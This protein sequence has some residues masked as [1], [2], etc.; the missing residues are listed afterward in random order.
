MKK[1]IIFGY[2]CLISFLA[3]GQDEIETTTRNADIAAQKAAQSAKEA[4]GS[5]A[6]AI[7]LAR[8][9]AVSAGIKIEEL[10]TFETNPVPVSLSGEQIM[11]TPQVVDQIP[12]KLTSPILEP[13]VTARPVK[14]AV[15]E[16]QPVYQDSF[17]RAE[18]VKNTEPSA[19][20]AIIVPDCGLEFHGYFRAGYLADLNSN[21]EKL[22][23]RDTAN[24]TDSLG[25]MG[26]EVNDWW[27]ASLIKKFQTAS[28]HWGK[29]TLT[30]GSVNSGLDAIDFIRFAGNSAKTTAILEAYVQLG[31]MEDAEASFWAGQR[32]YG[33]NLY[34]EITDFYYNDYSGTG[35]GFE[36]IPVGCGK[37][38]FAYLN[39]DFT[40]EGW[41]GRLTNNEGNAIPVDGGVF[42]ADD[43]LHAL[44]MNY[45]LANWDLG[46]MAKY[47]PANRSTVNE[48]RG[49]TDS[50]VEA[51][52][53]YHLDS[54][55]GLGDGCAHFIAQ[56]GQ[57]L[58]S[59]P[60]LGANFN[61]H[62]IFRLGADP[63][64]FINRRSDDVSY[65]A[66]TYGCFNLTDSIKLMPHLFFQQDNGQFDQTLVSGVFR[67]IYCLSDCL[68]LV[69]ETGISHVYTSDNV[70]NDGFQ[71]KSSIAPTYTFRNDLGQVSEFS[72]IAARIDG[73]AERGYQKSE[74]VMG[75]QA[76]LRW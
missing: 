9:A 60:G 57:G 19:K 5:A 39:S 54:F 76:V 28:G 66:S 62:N 30:Y 32:F 22:S 55:Y 25:R 58:S 49:F 16:H 44:H 10:D 65:R 41:L 36:N 38:D 18:V 70:A 48:R 45:S 24:R 13:I 6:R 12:V 74:S 37:L 34:S 26:L 46:V 2:L 4:A 52:V 68:S 35:L 17:V 29:S 14:H 27:Y 40:K 50:G 71:Y 43:M 31:I 59:G 8:E 1:I 73:D 21:N 56:A 20:D 11:D 64:D 75:L 61:T 72:L 3:L 51:M 69:S 7:K 23:Y 67:S 63:A 42:E 53:A 15:P 47:Y 33:R